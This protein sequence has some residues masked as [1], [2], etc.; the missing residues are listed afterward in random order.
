VLPVPVEP[1]APLAAGP[2]DDSPIGWPV[3][4]RWAFGVA[5]VG[6]ES[7]LLR[8]RHD[9]VRVLVEV[10]VKRRRAAPVHPDDEDVWQGAAILRP[11]PTCANR[12]GGEDKV[13]ASMTQA[14]SASTDTITGTVALDI[15]GLRVA[16]G[17]DWPEVIEDVRR[18]FAWFETDPA[19]NVDVEIFVERRA[20]DFEAF[21]PISASFVTP[22]N[23]V[24]KADGLTVVDYFG[25]ALSVLDRK[26]G[27][28]RIQGETPHLLHE[29]AYHFVLSRAGEHLDARGL[30]RLH[31][32]ALS[33]RG[34]AVVLVLPSGGGKSTL[35]SRALRDGT[36]R[37][38]A[39]DSPLIDRHGV[40]HPFP[41]RVG[42]NAGEAEALPPEHLR[43]IER[44]EFHPKLL[45]DLD[46]FPDG[47]ERSPRPIRDL[48]LGARSLAKEPRLE[49]VS[50][51]AAVIPLM[52]EAVVGVGLYQGMEFVLQK[53][54]VDVLAQARPALVRALCCAAVVRRASV[55]Q[56]TL[57]RD[58]DAN[59]AV[60][61]G[62]L[63]DA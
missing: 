54:P 61:R 9:Y 22:R 23:I 45:L 7:K 6:K 29:A 2:D 60:L 13:G 38:L 46:A 28:L 32:L 56:L 33:G 52:R 30:P 10:V 63:E 27:R 55:W 43:R 53:G 4:S 11:G 26:A 15:Y 8:P 1:P 44:M 18:D 37:L 16:V 40:I 20:P 57:G 51:R 48:V 50:R 42:L 35:A 59:W 14:P 3:K 36:F 39:E 31:G 58:Q 5:L 21:G 19:G 62:L 25:R 49:R 41:L 34:G 24:Y 12:H 47:V 17:G